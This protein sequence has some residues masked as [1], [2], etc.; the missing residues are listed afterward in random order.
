VRHPRCAK[1]MINGGE[2]RVRAQLSVVEKTLL[3]RHVSAPVLGHHQVSKEVLYE[4]TLPPVLHNFLI[5][6]FFRDLM[7]AQHWG[8]SMSSTQ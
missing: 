7:M 1:N 3:G 2:G 8:R 4:E 5:R 6:Y